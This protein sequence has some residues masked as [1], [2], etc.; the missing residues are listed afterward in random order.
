MRRIALVL[1]SIGTLIA[2][3]SAPVAAEGDTGRSSNPCPREKGVGSDGDGSNGGSLTKTVTRLDAADGSAMLTVT[4]TGRISKA[5]KI[6]LVD[7]VWLLGPAPASV[8]GARSAI[9]PTPI[10]VD[11]VVVTG[12]GSRQR[13]VFEVRV[14]NATDSTVCDRAFTTKKRGGQLR[15]D[16]R[17]N[18]VCVAS[19]PTPVIP[20]A[21]FAPLLASSAGVTAIL[22]AMRKRRMVHTVRA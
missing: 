14:P 16:R 20:E 6:T 21:P 3:P 2:V 17:S 11:N 10:R 1:A 4:L 12:S 8:A 9:K 22:L 13:A 5:Q 18:A 7:C 15:L 19:A